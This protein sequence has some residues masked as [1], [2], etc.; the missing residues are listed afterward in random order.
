MINLKPVRIA[1]R[2]LQRKVKLKRP[3]PGDYVNGIW[4][5]EG[6]EE[7]DILAAI[8]PVSTAELLRLPEG[9]RIDATH[10][11]WTETELRAADEKEKTVSDV[12]V[13]SLGQEFAIIKVANRD[14]AGFFRAIGTLKYDRGRSI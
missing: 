12:I 14:E 1:I 8:C 3:P 2:A 6:S 13:N 4:Q 10:I 9:M 7:T 5:G 11:I